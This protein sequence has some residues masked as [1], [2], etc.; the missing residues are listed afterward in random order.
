MR[1]HGPHAICKGLCGRQ[2]SEDCVG[3]QKK[4]EEKKGRGERG[5]CKG[6]KGECT[7]TEQK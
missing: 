7:R 3:G 6:R 4:R 2:S 5:E 1:F